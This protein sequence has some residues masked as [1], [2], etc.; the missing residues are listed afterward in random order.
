MCHDITL[1]SG[2]ER[3]KYTYISPSLLLDK[4]PYELQLQFYYF[5]FIIYTTYIYIYIYIYIK[6]PSRLH[7]HIDQKLMF[8]GFQQWRVL[9]HRCK[10]VAI[11][12]LNVL[13]N[14]R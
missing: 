2:A 9:K 13:D 3:V 6:S 7:H 11:K 1:H 12:H 5:F 8:H 4:S 14:F 10:T